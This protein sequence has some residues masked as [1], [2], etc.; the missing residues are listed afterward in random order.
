MLKD[1]YMHRCHVGHFP[2][3]SQIHFLPFPVLVCSHREVNYT[4]SIVNS[5]WLS[6]ARSQRWKEEGN[7]IFPSF[8]AI[9]Q[10]SHAFSMVPLPTLSFLHTVLVM[11]GIAPAQGPKE[12]ALKYTLSHFPS[13][14]K[15]V[16]NFLLLP[17]YS[18]L[19]SQLSYP[20]YNQIPKLSFLY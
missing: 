20:L 9:L 4:G 14:L 17:Q 15:V 7:K 5:S 10:H 12:W 3:C 1:K 11:D 16:S 2:L 19:I 13:S 8:L 6:W 18:C